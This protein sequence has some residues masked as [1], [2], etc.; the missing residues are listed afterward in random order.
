MSEQMKIKVYMGPTDSKVDQLPIG[1]LL[2]VLQGILPTQNLIT[3]GNISSDILLW[4]S[5][6]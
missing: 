1:L 2:S 3:E 6:G 5:Q 4:V